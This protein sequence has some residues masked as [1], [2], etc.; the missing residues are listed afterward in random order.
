MQ[1][2]RRGL[3]WVVPAFVLSVMVAACSAT[4]S[5]PKEQTPA[6]Q[7]QAQAKPP[8][9][10]VVKVR[11]SEVIHSVFYAPQYVA[12]A[13]GYFKDE[14]IDLDTSTA[15]GSD[16][17]TAALL[18]GTAD[19]ALVGPETTIFVYNQETPVKIKMFA[20]LTA[21]DGSFLMARQPN[22][23]FKWE[24][25]RGKNIIGWRVGSMPQMVAGSVLKKT[26][27]TAGKDVTYVTNLA[28]TAMAGAFQAGQ[29]DYIQLYEPVVSTLEKAGSAYVVASMGQA[30]GP[31]PF[32][33]YAA[34]D[35]FIK[36]N[37]DVVQR[38][39]NAIYRAMLYVQKTDAATIAKEI[40]SQ[41]EG[42]DVALIES[43]IKRYK[44][45]DTWKVTPVMEAKDFDRLQEL[46]VE[47]T[48]LEAAKRAPFDKIVDNSFAEKAV[49]EIK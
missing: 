41:F 37:P 32:T 38:Y 23:N 21:K 47:G 42:T 16:R 6:K 25:T 10:K 15:Q 4:G 2:Q 39:T 19:I 7:E 43:A 26:G 3:K 18:A 22:P 14:A 28:S 1:F 45:Q 9:K 34:T 33:G 8:E 48:V 12:Q 29:G 30:Y 44:A 31:V 35:K 20:Q 17:G 11:F 49:K 27:L 46:M 36:E 40:A 24:D 5:A 13:K